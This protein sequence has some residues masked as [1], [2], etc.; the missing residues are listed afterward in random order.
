[1]LGNSHDHLKERRSWLGRNYITRTPRSRLATTPSTTT[2]MSEHTSRTVKYLKSALVCTSCKPEP[3]TIVS[4]TPTGPCGDCHRNAWLAVAHLHSIA[5]SCR[6][7]SASTAGHQTCWPDDPID[8]ESALAGDPGKLALREFEMTI[9]EF[10]LR[11]VGVKD[12]SK[13]LDDIQSLRPSDPVASFHVGLRSVVDQVSA[14]IGDQGFGDR[15]DDQMDENKL[16]NICGYINSLGHTLSFN[17]LCWKLKEEM[18]AEVE[19][20]SHDRPSLAKV[21]TRTDFDPIHFWPTETAFTGPHSVAVDNMAKGQGY[22]FRGFQAQ[23]S[24]KEEMSKWLQ[25]KVA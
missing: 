21:M 18:D 14:L 12:P 3:V 11:R 13:Y 6:E 17:S 5:A 24:G 2:I 19:K 1:M 22:L 4:S 23:N 25:N 9:A 10:A 20:G 16:G 8:P 7:R 15:T